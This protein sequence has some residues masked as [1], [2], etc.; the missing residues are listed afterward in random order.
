M[1]RKTNKEF[2]ADVMSGDLTRIKSAIME[3]VALEKCD[4][5]KA[6]MELRKMA[7]DEGREDLALLVNQASEATTKKNLKIFF[8]GLTIAVALCTWGISK[9]DSYRDWSRVEQEKD[10][11]VW[12]V[13]VVL[14]DNLKD[15]S[16]YTPISWGTLQSFEDGG[17]TVTHTYR[18]KNSFGVYS[19]STVVAKIDKSGNV[20]LLGE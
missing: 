10:G 4:V 5:Q 6:T 17:Y 9:C 11:S 14:K 15:R 1:G 3:Y 8:I 12:Q 7:R 19:V 18:A 2:K 16:S 13:R 20:T